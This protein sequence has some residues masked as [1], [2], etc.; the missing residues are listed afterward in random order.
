MRII[1]GISG[2]SGVVMGYALMRALRQRED[3]EIHL[4]VTDGARKTWDLETDLPFEKLLEL[5]DFCH[6]DA[7]LA[8]SISSG[9]FHTDG[10]IVIPCSMKTLSGIVAGYSANLLV[11]AVDVCLKENRRVILVPREMPLSKVHLRNLL[12]AADLGCTIIP[13]VLTF[14]NKLERTTDQI[15]HVIGKILMQLGMQYSEFSPWEGVDG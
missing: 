14:Y 8:A 12:D 6:S 9:S 4:V 1:V 3:C 5:A 15:N 11:R 7:N 2:A 10:M 13:P